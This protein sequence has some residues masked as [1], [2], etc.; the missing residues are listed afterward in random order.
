LKLASSS[1][2]AFA[3]PD[4]EAAFQAHQAQAVNLLTWLCTLIN[5]AGYCVLVRKVAGI[6]TSEQSVVLE[7]LPWALLFQLAP[8]VACLLLMIVYR[9]FYSSNKQAV[10]LV[11]NSCV[12]F[13]MPSARQLV[14][15]MRQSSGSN[16][17][18]SLLQ[19][20]QTFSDENLF[21]TSAWFSV[22]GFPA[23][24]LG[25]FAYMAGMVVSYLSKN[26]HVCASTI[27]HS[28]AVTLWPGPLA[29]AQ[30]VS[31]W[32]LEAAAPFYTPHTKAVTSCTA[33]LGVW[34]LVGSWLGCMAGCLAEI[35]R[36]RAFL[37]TPAARDC[38]GRSFAS[39]ALRW[40]LGSFCLAAKFAQLV[41]LFT[42]A[43]C[44]LWAVALDFLH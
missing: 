4:L 15:W 3:S 44:I 35:S 6:D 12:V 38:L 16:P 14:L 43:H 29:A 27:W 10:H 26:N 24:Q 32:M 28:D 11:A 5:I 31:T 13:G 23:G 18:S 42:L 9:G 8:T 22:A 19:A 36:R 39:S 33:A 21:L 25:D 34:Q 40:P 17:S 2:F 37:R 1:I 41:L 7:Y 20:M 30:W